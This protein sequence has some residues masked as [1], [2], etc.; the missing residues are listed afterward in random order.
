[1]E[2]NK[3]IRSAGTVGLWV[4]VSRVLGLLRDVSLAAVFGS[5]PAMDAYVVAFTIP[6]LFRSLFGEG[7]LSAAFVPVFSD[8]LEKSGR[9]QVWIFALRM[10][11]LLALT[12]AILTLVGFLIITLAASFLPLSP[13]FLLIGKLLR[14]M[15]PYMFFICLSAFFS[16]MLNALHKF[17]LP[18]A[19]PVI[20]NLTII[21]TLWC[22]CPKLPAEGD[23]R[24]KMVAWSILFAGFFQ[25]LTPL[26]S[27][28][29]QGFRLR[30]DTNWRD[31]RVQKVLQLMAAAAVGVGVTQINVLCDRLIALGLGESCPSYLYYA[32]RLIFLPL[33]VFAT[34][35][36]VVLLPVFSRQTAQADPGHMR[37]TL[38]YALRQVLFITLPAAAGLLFLAHPI[39]QVMYRQGGFSA[40]DARHTAIAL[41][42]YAPGLVMFSLLKVLVPYFY[43]QKDIRT[44]VLV[45]IV[46]SVINIVLSLILMYPLSYAGI[47]VATVIASI[48]QVASLIIIIHKRKGSHG[49]S[50]IAL[51]GLRLILPVT[52]L[53]F[54]ALQVQ[55]H[56]LQFMGNG[57]YPAKINEITALAG[58]IGGG[59]FVYFLAA[60]AF[61]CEEVKEI[62][63]SIFA[64]KK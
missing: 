47:A 22:L 39:V 28:R 55:A 32:E 49:W 41:A 10:L 12:L 42:C 14:I 18:A 4:M 56:I 6:N 16:A 3:L 2:A 50:R 45:G 44:P 40:V 63:S 53:V 13:R 58:S 27:L 8:T 33:G 35:I 48:I 24:I 52:G 11:S 31:Q 26:C 25:A 54:T 62:L 1:M 64:F 29:R 5:S 34:S 21:F 43:A 9:E 59:I 37:A 51:T 7:A 38:N 19:V 46:C 17:A 23:T 61:R 30:R 60:W 36:G 57:G 20:L 15:L